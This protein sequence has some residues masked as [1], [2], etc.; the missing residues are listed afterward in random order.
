MKEILKEQEKRKG[1]IAAICAGN[2]RPA[3][4]QGC[5]QFSRSVVSDSCDP[6]NCSSLLQNTHD[7]VVF[8]YKV[9]FP[10]LLPL[11]EA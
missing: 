2:L 7:R 5:L 1:L 4:V 8:E 6:M 10:V 11:P 9:V 3:P